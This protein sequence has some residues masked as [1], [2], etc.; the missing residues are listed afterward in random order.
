MSFL[1]SPADSEASEDCFEAMKVVGWKNRAN[2][3][4]QLS[5]G[6]KRMLEIGI[7]LSSAE[8]SSPGRTLRIE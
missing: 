6:A 5:Y 3:D 2:H 8:A 1:F 7:A 4:L